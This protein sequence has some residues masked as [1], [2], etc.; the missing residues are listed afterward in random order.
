[1]WSGYRKETDSWRRNEGLTLETSCATVA[2]TKRELKAAIIKTGG[3]PILWQQQFK[4]LQETQV[5]KESFSCS[6][7]SFSCR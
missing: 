6:C 7:T 1:M 5:L 2:C 4:E 3:S